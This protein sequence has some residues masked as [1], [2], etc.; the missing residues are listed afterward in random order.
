[1]KT[2]LIAP[3][4]W[5]LANRTLTVATAL[6]C[7]ALC[8]SAWSMDLSEAYQAAMEQDATL[9]ATR[10]A[11]DSRR[12]RVPQ[13]RAQL[14]PNISA[15]VSRNRNA[16]DSTTPN[17]LGNAVTTHT[18]YN[19]SSQGVT[20]RQPLFHAYQMADYRQ[21]KAQVDDAEAILERELQNVAVRA[22]SSWLV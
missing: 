5:R 4:R 8:T 2:S 1:M 17:F 16:L 12:E 21:A 18:N 15:N 6:M 13:T 9:R 3:I 20:L 14:L 19:S 7:G 10:A 22:E 11:T